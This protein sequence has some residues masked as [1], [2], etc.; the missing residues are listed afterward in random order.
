MFYRLSLAIT[1]FAGKIFAFDLNNMYR[2]NLDNLVL[3]DTFEGV[4]CIG[5]DSIVVTDMGMFFCDYQG[6]YWHNGQKAE[7][8]GTPILKSSYGEDITNVIET[9]P[10]K[11]KK[12]SNHAWQDISHKIPPKIIYDPKTISAF[13]CFQNAKSYNNIEYTFNG[14]WKFNLTRKRLDL[15]QLPEIKGVLTGQRNDSYISGNQKLYRL[16]KSDIERE[17]Y[18][19][20]SKKFD[21]GTG[22]EEKAF[23]SVKLGFNNKAAATRWI[24]SSS[25][26]DL[27]TNEESTTININQKI[28]QDNNVVVYKIPGSDR[29]AKWLKIHIHSASE[30]IDSISIVYRQK[31]VK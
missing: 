7:N 16:T 19:F 22:S 17:N 13:F 11:D 1:W 23:Y 10:I 15:V 29:K 12:F 31:K 24:A 2:I 14:A 4:G 20:Y 28:E 30:E 18:N 9:N 8:I 3:E 6:L 26:V 21:M 27:L 5:P 25:S